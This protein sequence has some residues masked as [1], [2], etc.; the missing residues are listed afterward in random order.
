MR[1]VFAVFRYQ[2]HTFQT[3]MWDTHRPI[4]FYRL[5]LH[6]NKSVA[7][8]RIWKWGH[9]SGA[10]VGK[11]TDP[12]RRKKFLVVSL[13]FFDSKSTIIR[14]SAR[15]RGGQ[16]S[17]VSFLFAVLVLTVPSCQPLVKVGARAPRALWSQ[18]HC[19]KPTQKLCPK[20]ICLLW[21]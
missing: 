4:C 1:Q 12:E 17:L 13:H 10:K 11:G 15:F 20:P 2:F 19:K 6:H 21:I 16:Y 18:R 3:L 5:N 7:P 9:R 14:F 8:K